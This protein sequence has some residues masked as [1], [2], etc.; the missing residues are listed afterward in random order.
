MKRQFQVIQ[1]L[2]IEDLVIFIVKFVVR[3]TR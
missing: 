2:N 1:A 3:K